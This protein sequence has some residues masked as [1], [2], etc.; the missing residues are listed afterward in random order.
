MLFYA[1]SE[2]SVDV[3]II[4]SSCDR[5]AKGFA[6]SIPAGSFIPRRNNGVTGQCRTQGVED[7]V[8]AGPQRRN[9]VVRVRSV[10]VGELEACTKASSTISAA[11]LGCNVF[12]Q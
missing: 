2:C 12:A 11:D 4:I 5:R 6:A 7:F 10:S 1:N 3:I 8:E 9:K